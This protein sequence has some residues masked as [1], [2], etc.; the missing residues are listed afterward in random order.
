[1]RILLAYFRLHSV[2]V[3]GLIYFLLAGVL[4]QIPLFNYVGYEFSAAMTIPT[5]VVSGLL[6][7]SFIRIHIHQPIS[8]RMFL[9]VLA[10]YFVVNLVLLIIPLAVMSANAFAVKNCSFPRG[11]LYYVLLPVMTMIFSVSLATVAGTLFRHARLIFVLIIAGIISHILIV[12]YTEPQLFAYNAVIGFFPGI[13]YDESL[14]DVSTLLIYREFTLIASLMFIALFFLSVRMIW[15]DYKFHE[16]VQ[17]FRIRKGDRMLYGAVVVCLLVLVYGHYERDVLGFQYSASEIQRQ[18]GGRAATAHF[19]VYYPPER[20]SVGEMEIL[21]AEVE[22]H[23]GLVVSRMKE[24]LHSGEKIS[25]YLYPT[26]ES[27]RRF[28]G[29]STTNIAKPWRKEMHLTLDSFDD[30]FR[31]ELVHILAANIGLPIVR[32]SARMGLNEGLATAIDWSWGEF[33]PHEY[34]AALQREQLLDDPEELFAYTGFATRQSSYA[35]VVAGS[36]SRYLIDRFGVKSFKEVFPAG[37][38]VA[39]YGLPLDALIEDWKNFLKTVDASSLPPETIRT[40]F[41]QQ[42]IFRKTCARVTAERNARAVQAIRVKDYAEAENEFSTSFEDAQTAFALRGLF[43]SLLAGKKYDRLVEMYDALDGR[44]MLRYNPG[45]LFL[46][47]DALWLQGN[48]L[49][50]LEVFRRVEE[51]NYS[52]AYTE[53]AALRR[54]IVREPRLNRPLRDYFY[55]NASDSARFAI[56]NGLLQS[57]ESR[58]VAKYLQAHELLRLKRYSEAGEAFRAVVWAFSDS[59]LSYA[60]AVNAAR[61]LYRAGRFEEAKGMFWQAQ[62]FTQSPTKVQQ[63][64]EWI[65]RCDA[66]EAE[67]E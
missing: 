47:A 15:P 38:F 14:S 62:N 37:H 2:R 30:T 36:F 24:T 23:Y 43:Q 59:L 16:N 57:D 10:H 31:H 45:I 64:K 29:T 6:T 51:M 13:T 60:A 58:V 25:V 17:A 3:A 22:Y 49:H 28:V 67:I 46:L 54:V 5:A 34:S 18:L 55:G 56:V 66:V 39:S 27:K 19:I 11:L 1:M 35:Y 7:I 40:L 41:A 12:T 42:S 52:E 33:S 8:R 50:S 65:E 9:L 48:V 20:V 26:G 61:A 32:A 21:K 44:S 4:T 53:S 63:V